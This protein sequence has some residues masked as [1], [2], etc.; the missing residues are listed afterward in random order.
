MIP[1]PG[2]VPYLHGAVRVR[3]RLRCG[4]RRRIAPPMSHTVQCSACMCTCTRVTR[5]RGRTRTCRRPHAG[6]HTHRC[7]ENR[8]KHHKCTY[9]S[10]HSKD[11]T[12]YAR[13]QLSGYRGTTRGL[14][15][16]HAHT[17]RFVQE[18]ACIASAACLHRHV[19]APRPYNIPYRSV[20]Q[21]QGS[22][23]NAHA[24]VHMREREHSCT[25]RAHGTA[26]RADRRG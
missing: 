7:R 13:T 15:G 16:P 5:T 18:G 12:L 24:Y 4:T 10:M 9:D 1:V 3:P 21:V 11:H 14:C 22:V 2:P 17:L 26:K 6:T 23:P 25:T 19:D 8:C 20:Q